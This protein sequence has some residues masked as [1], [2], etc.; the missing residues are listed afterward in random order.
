MKNILI[1]M[2]LILFFSCRTQKVKSSWVDN[3]III[4]GIIEDWKD[5]PRTF[6]KDMKMMFSIANND[7]NL[8]IMYCFND[9]DLARMIDVRGI[10][11]WFNNEGN[12]DKILG[13]S[14]KREFDGTPESHKKR[15]DSDPEKR[16]EF[17][18][19]M[20]IDLSMLR[21]M[22]QL[23]DSLID[24]PIE[25]ISGYE[26][27]FNKVDGLYG[28]EIKVPVSEIAVLNTDRKIPKNRRLS[29]GIE[30]P[31]A[32]MGGRSEK[33]QMPKMSG[34]GMQ[35]GR[36]GMGGDRGGSPPGFDRQR[37]DMSAKALWVNI[38]LSENSIPKL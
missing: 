30:I 37:P 36:G 9:P 35:G 14:F 28:F 10:I 1:L 26:A 22:V 29:I 21:F 8:Y 38:V 13:I 15:L 18:R 33:R 17:D 7:E 16:A 32:K 11:V 19:R 12:K 2:V 25:T 5:I 31:E 20:Q 3:Q 23:R 27:G 4:D 24:M 34:G 6:D